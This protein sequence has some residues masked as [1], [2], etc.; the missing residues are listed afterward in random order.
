MPASRSNIDLNAMLSRWQCCRILVSKKFREG[1][2]PNRTG[3]L[4]SE[5]WLTGRVGV[6]VYTNRP[7]RS[8]IGV[9]DVQIIVMVKRFVDVLVM[10][11]NQ[12]VPLIC[13]A[14]TRVTRYERGREVALQAMSEVIYFWRGWIRSMQL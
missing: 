3:D 2:S 7:S 1:L 11:I 5:E 6:N 13:S 10:I 12:S 14:V 4:Y 9:R 8:S